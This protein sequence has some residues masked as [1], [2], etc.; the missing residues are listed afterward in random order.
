MTD[1]VLSKTVSPNV[2]V[3][4]DVQRGSRCRATRCAHLLVPLAGKWSLSSGVLKSV[5]VV[6][7]A[8]LCTATSYVIAGW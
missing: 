3:C 1:N 4:V 2:E 5:A 8:S 7:P 6:F